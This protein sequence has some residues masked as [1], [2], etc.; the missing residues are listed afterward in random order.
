MWA[1]RVTALPALKSPCMNDGVFAF[2]EPSQFTSQQLIVHTC[3]M[4]T[5]LQH[6]VFRVERACKGVMRES[7][8]N[9]PQGHWQMDGDAAAMYTRILQAICGKDS[10]QRRLHIV[11][12]R[13]FSELTLAAGAGNMAAG[14]HAAGAV[15]DA[16]A[17]VPSSIATARALLLPWRKSN[18]HNDVNGI[19]D[20]LWNLSFS[21]PLLEACSF[22]TWW[23]LVELLVDAMKTYPCSDEA[24]AAAGDTSAPGTCANG[25]PGWAMLTAIGLLAQL[26]RVIVVNPR[27]HVLEPIIFNKV[28]EAVPYLVGIMDDEWMHQLRCPQVILWLAFSDA[29]AELLAQNDALLAA[30]R[31]IKARGEAMGEGE[32]KAIIMS[33]VPAVLLLIERAMA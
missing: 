7:L 5:I 33:N 17:W 6:L 28:M 1:A 23:A 2:I 19:F 14:E 16:V 25:N 8:V 13:V 24:W 20:Q 15:E 3:C 22:G 21:P 29:H 18:P 32:Y 27:Y 30:L 4:L 11:V 9:A 10:D 12:L 26:L 31:S